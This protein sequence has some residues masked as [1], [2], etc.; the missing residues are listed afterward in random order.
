MTSD[1][2]T[3]LPSSE[4]ASTTDGAAK[5]RSTSPARRVGA[6]LLDPKLLWRSL[7]RRAPQARSTD[8]V[9]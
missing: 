5:Q 2:S 8:T 4:S 6:G 7:P 1:R 9:A 3:V